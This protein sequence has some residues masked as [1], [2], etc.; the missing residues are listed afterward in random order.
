MGETI[1]AMLRLAA[2]PL[3]YSAPKAA[4]NM[5][6]VLL[7]KELR[8]TAIKV[9]SAAP[10]RTQ[11]DMGG[12]ETPNTVP[13]GAQ[14]AVWLACLEADD[15]MAAFLATSGLIPGRTQ[16]GPSHWQRAATRYSRGDA[17]TVSSKVLFACY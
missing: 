8:D 13:Q 11:T 16:A 2:R 10:S 9:N 1:H 5:F 7:A 17:A 6:S 3:G 12:P 15:L 4:L 14:V